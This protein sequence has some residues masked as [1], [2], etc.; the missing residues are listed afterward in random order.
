MGML[1]SK[2]NLS[3]YKVQIL[4]LKIF[5]GSIRTMVNIEKNNILEK[6]YVTPA[7]FHLPHT[8]GPFLK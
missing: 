8:N 1:K 3:L 2:D 6:H 5:L 7:S 4:R